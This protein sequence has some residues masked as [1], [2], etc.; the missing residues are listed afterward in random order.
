MLYRFTKVKMIV[1]LLMFLF[2]ISN[3]V[4]STHFHT[5]LE[6]QVQHECALCQATIQLKVSLSVALNNTFNLQLLSSAVHSV[7]ILIFP[8]ST[9]LVK[10]SQAPPVLA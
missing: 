9:P 6:S 3:F 8:N 5:A 1:A 4:A 2:G 10:R 7:R